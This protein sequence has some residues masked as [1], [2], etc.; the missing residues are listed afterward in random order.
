MSLRQISFETLI[1]IRETQATK[2][3]KNAWTRTTDNRV[4]IKVLYG[5][6]KFVEMVVFPRKKVLMLDQVPQILRN[7]LYR[8]K[9]K[10]VQHFK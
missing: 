10:L 4:F 7:K 9:R 6:M 2:V 8:F 5:I 1:Y 3:H